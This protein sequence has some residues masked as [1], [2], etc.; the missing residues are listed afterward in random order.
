VDLNGAHVALNRLKLAAVQHLPDHD[1]FFRFFGHADNAEN[2]SEYDR[3]L[4][5]QLDTDSRT[6][7][8]GRTLTG[9]RRV[10]RFTTG[11]YRTGLLGHF[12]GI[13]HVM[14]RRLGADPRK[15]LQARTL[16][17][18][19]DIFERELAPLFDRRLVRW[20]TGSP[21]SLYGLGIPPAQY[22]ALSGGKSMAIVLRER[23]ERLACDFPLQDNYFAQQAFGR[24]YQG[25][26]DT[27]LPPYL[28]RGNFDTVRAN[29]GRVAVRHMSVTDFLVTLPQSSMDRYVLLDAQDWM[30]DRDLT[31]LW[32]QITRT[33]RPGARVIFR[34]AAS[35]TLLPGRIPADIL[36]R[37][38]YDADRSG[39]LGAQDRSAIYGGF[40]LYVRKD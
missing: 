15:M 35:E 13:G 4:A 16:D 40:H 6:Y 7:W 38:T 18:Q 26:S 29:A 9:K 32:T 14:A 3:L 37:W 30:T 2:V 23:V 10:E 8:E 5:P 33:A 34:T 27:G 1:A 24:Q 39:E 25:T 12:I 28:V 20:L 22:E 21:A 11:F 17:E 36:Y 31:R 19:R